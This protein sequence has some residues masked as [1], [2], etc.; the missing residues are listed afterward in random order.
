M[1]NHLDVWTAY[2]QKKLGLSDWYPW[3]FERV[4]G[5]IVMTGAVMPLKLDGRPNVRNR[6]KATETKVLYPIED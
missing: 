4:L 1:D 6:D 3:K 5:G 2:A